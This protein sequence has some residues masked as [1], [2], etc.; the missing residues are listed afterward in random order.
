MLIKLS[1]FFTKLKNIALL[2]FLTVLVACDSS[3]EVPANT[4][5]TGNTGNTEGQVTI[6]GNAVVGAILRASVTDANGLANSS[7]TYQWQVAGNPIANSNSDT[8]VVTDIYVSK[9]ITVQATYTDGAGFAESIVAATEPVSSPTIINNTTTAPVSSPTVINNTTT[10]PVSSPT[11]INNNVAVDIDIE[12][13]DW[14]LSIPID[15]GDG[16]STSI[17]ETTLANGYED[18]EFFMVNDDGSI[19]MRCPTMGYKTSENT[20]YVRTELRE[21]LRRGN[22]SHKTQGINKNNWVFS[23]YPQSEQDAA[24]GVDGTLDVTMKVSHVSVTGDNYQIGRV[25]IGQIHAGSDEPIRLYY[26]KLPNNE[27]GSIYFAHELYEGDDTWYEMIG[28]RDNDASNP[29]DGIAL[30]EVFSYT[31]D[32]EANTLTVVIQRQGKADVVTKVDMSNSGYHTNSEYQ[33]FK[34]GVYHLNN[35]GTTAE[36]YVEATFYKIIN[37]H[38]GYDF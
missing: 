5:N 7:M 38:K 16:R 12:L 8:L 4:G 21:M 32:V 10:A 28:E 22:T 15:R 6:N 33:Y 27:N 35:S 36:D 1:S 13:I 30:N 19:T 11:V 26:R 2:L 14:Y 9:T 31:I 25:V 23:S 37:K 3:T 29:A 20:K 18:D 24:G 17:D 34:V